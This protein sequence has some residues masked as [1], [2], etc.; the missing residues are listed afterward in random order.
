MNV[1]IH[2]INPS[3]IIQHTEVAS[4]YIDGYFFCVA[5]PDKIYKYRIDN[6]WLILEDREEK[7]AE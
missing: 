4:T 3:E 7:A 6:L 2:V 5:E 1:T